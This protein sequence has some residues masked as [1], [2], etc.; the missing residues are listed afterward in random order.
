[1]S[2]R[3]IKIMKIFLKKMN[4]KVIIINSI[5]ARMTFSNFRVKV[6]SKCSFNNSSSSSRI[7]SIVNNLVNFNSKICNN[8]SSSSSIWMKFKFIL[9]KAI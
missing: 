1:M 3:K 4:W 2:F 6:I 5:I 8:S 9:H 7:S